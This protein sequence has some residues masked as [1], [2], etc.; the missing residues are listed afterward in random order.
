[1]GFTPVRLS[2]PKPTA[3]SRPRHIIV[4]FLRD[5]AKMS[6]LAAARKKG[7]IVWKGMRVL[8]FQDYAQE[9]QEKRRKFDESCFMGKW[10]IPLDKFV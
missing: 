2:F 5:K 1:R 6:V 3:D 10:D 8:F 4:R 7:Q 9:V